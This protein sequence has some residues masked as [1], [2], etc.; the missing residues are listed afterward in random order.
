MT[1]LF[2][3][4]DQQLLRENK[5]ETG[6]VAWIPL[7]EFSSQSSEEEMKIIYDK[8]IS[9]IIEKKK[10]LDK[11]VEQEKEEYSKKLEKYKNMNYSEDPKAYSELG[12][13]LF[14]KQQDSKEKVAILKELKELNSSQEECKKYLEELA[15]PDK[16]AA[17]NISEAFYKAA[18]DEEIYGSEQPVEEQ[19]A[20]NAKISI[21][22]GYKDGIIIYSDSL[23]SEAK[24]INIQE[25]KSE[26]KEKYKRLGIKEMC[27]EIADGKWKALQLKRKVDPVVIKAIERKPL[28]IKEYIKAIYEEKELPFELTQNLT[29]IGVIER[30]KL[31]KYIDVEEKCGAEIV[32]KINLKEK[33]VGLLKGS[34]NKIKKLPAKALDKVTG[35][36]KKEEGKNLQVH[37]GEVIEYTRKHGIEGIKVEETPK[38]HQ[39]KVSKEQEYEDVER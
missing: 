39:V 33:I 13:E 27:N 26:Q 6:G 2:E 11:I 14:G 30:L 24:E 9:R 18:R 10:E 28:M 23:L 21:N 15:I 5:E 29:G 25:A 16:K 36:A 8:I 35:K 31:K 19:S 32:G 22:V 12:K 37:I 1:F 38:V 3:A 20:A 7:E 34:S 4:D 17:K